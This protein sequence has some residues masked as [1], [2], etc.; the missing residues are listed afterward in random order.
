V[1]GRLRG[2]GLL[3]RTITLK[4]RDED[5]HTTTHAET[6]AAPIDSSNEVYR[7]AQKL[8]EEVHARKKV[9]LLGIYVSG[10]GTLG[11]QL[12]LFAEVPSP[13][14][15]LRDKLKERFGDGAVT[16]ATLLGKAERRNPSDL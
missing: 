10:L 11:G 16:R 6:L 15:Q 7:V 8:F 4:Y 12:G 2:Q 14:D 3:G 5:F 9:R 13:A 1:A